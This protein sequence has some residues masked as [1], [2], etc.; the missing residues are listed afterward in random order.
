MNI[1]G[2]KLEDKTMR[3][4]DC[5]KDF[6]FTIGEQKYF[7]SKELSPPKRCPECREKRRTSIVRV[8]GE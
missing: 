8:G 3:C 5:D 4:V 7:I 1:N 6:A 2:L